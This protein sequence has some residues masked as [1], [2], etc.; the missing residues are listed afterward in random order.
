LIITI[1]FFVNLSRN[2]RRRKAIKLQ[3]NIMASIVV[4]EDCLVLFIDDN[5]REASWVVGK[6][7]ILP[8]VSF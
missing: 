3:I 8:I 1:I 4:F 7:C 6:Y 2:V 5:E